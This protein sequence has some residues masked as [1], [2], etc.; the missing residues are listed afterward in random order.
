VDRCGGGCVGVV[1]RV[2]WVVCGQAW[3]I[4]GRKEAQDKLGG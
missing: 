1:G 3:D 2:L 4:K